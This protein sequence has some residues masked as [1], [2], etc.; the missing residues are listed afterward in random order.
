MTATTHSSRPPQS[1]QPDS[2][3]ISSPKK[4]YM[5][6]EDG[7]VVFHE[8]GQSRVLG[9]FYKLVE[10]KGLANLD[11]PEELQDTLRWMQAFVNIHRRNTGKDLHA[12]R[13]IDDVHG[14]DS[15]LFVVYEPK[16]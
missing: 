7:N 5:E 3:R 11:V 16:P 13:F 2:R 9:E 1:V 14:T 8:G 15:T 12:K 4:S 10:T 6:I